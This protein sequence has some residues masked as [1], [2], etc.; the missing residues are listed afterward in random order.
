MVQEHTG[1]TQER[2]VEMAILCNMMVNAE[3]CEVALAQLREDYF[4]D[5]RN[6]VL[7]RAMKA[8]GFLRQNKRFESLNGYL[9]QQGLLDAVG[10]KGYLTC[11]YLFVPVCDIDSFIRLLILRAA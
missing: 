7:F 2:W 6:R 3:I 10:G 5:E 11:V 4:E 9:T 1:T 8:L